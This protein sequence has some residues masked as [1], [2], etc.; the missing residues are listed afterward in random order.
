MK[1]K[2]TKAK[3][4]CR[5][6]RTGV[7]MNEHSLDAIASPG[8]YKI[9]ACDV[10]TSEG[11]P[12]DVAQG[13]ISAYLEVSVTNRRR[14]NLKSNTIGQT[15]TLTDGSGTTAMY[16]RNSVN[17]NGKDVWE[18]W[19]EVPVN[20]ELGSVTSLDGY[21]TNG[22][23]RGTYV[24]GGVTEEFVLVVVQN[25]SSATK[26]V[27]QYKYAL[28]SDGT[29]INKVRVGRIGNSVTWGTWTEIAAI[30]SN[31]IQD[32]SVTAAKLSDDVREKV[33]L[34]PHLY[35]KV[36]ADEH[37]LVNGDIIV[38]QAREVYSR[39]GKR[40]K[41]TFL[42]RTTA[43]GTTISD[44]VASIKQIGGNI[45]KNLVDGTSIIGWA[46]RPDTDVSINNGIITIKSM[47]TDGKG[48]LGY[49]S[50]TSSSTLISGHKF[51]ASCFIKSETMPNNG[52]IVGQSNEDNTIRPD[53]SVC[54]GNNTLWQYIS[55]YEALPMLTYYSMFAIG[56]KRTEGIGEIYIKNPLLVDLTEMYGAGNEPTKEECDKM[57]GV[58]APLPQGLTVAQPT[59]LKSVG[60]NQWNPI[61][62]MEGKGFVDG[63]LADVADSTIAIVECLPCQVGAGEN[64]GYVI[65][66]GEGEEWS[67][68]GVEV[69][70][71]PINPLDAESELYL[72]KL[73]KDATY[74]T[75]LPGIAGYLLVVTPT[76]DKLCAHLHWSG[77]RAATDYEP[78]NEST[79]QLPDIP[80]MSEWG[81]AG[82]VANGNIVQDTIDLENNKYIKRIG[83]I[84]LNGAE[85]W[86]FRDN[87]N[88][89]YGRIIPE[90]GAITNNVVIEAAIPFV[91]QN[92]TE[93][94]GTMAVTGNTVYINYSE[95]VNALGVVEFK[96]YLRNNPIT[97]YYA[98]ATP[99]EY[100]IVTKSAPNYIGGDYGVEQFTGS[101][102]PLAAN[103]LL[104][105]R[106]LVSETRNF[107]DQLYQNIGVCDSNNVANY[108]TEH[109]D[110]LKSNTDT[111]VK[112]ENCFSQSLKDLKV[113]HEVYINAEPFELSDAYLSVRKSNDTQQISLYSDNNVVAN[114]WT[115]RNLIERG[116]VKLTPIKDSGVTAYVF[117]DFTQVDSSGVS[118]VSISD[119]RVFTLAYSPSIAAEINSGSL[120]DLYSISNSI[121]ELN[122][123]VSHHCSY[124][125]DL[126]YLNLL[127]ELY[128]DGINSV[129]DYPR[130]TLR[131]LSS[132]S[133][134]Q[135]TLYS[136]YDTSAIANYWTD[137]NFINK[138]IVKLSQSNNSGVTAYAFV[139]F[140]QL[141]ATTSICIT[142]DNVKEIAFSPSIA[143]YLNDNRILEVEEN[144]KSLGS[145]WEGK[146]LLAIG[147]SITTEWSW[148]KR[149][150]SKCAAILGMNVR[151]HAKGGIGL[152]Q[153][154][155]GDGSGD[156]PEGYDPD[157][158]G[159]EELYALNS[160]DVTDVD[161]IVLHGMYN[162]R[163]IAKTAF[164]EITDMYPAQ[165]TYL[166]RLQYAIS[167]IY[168]ELEKAGNKNCK[169]VICSAHKYGKYPY[170][171]LSAYDD[172]EP[173]RLGAEMV[174]KYHSLYFIDLMNL[175]NINKYNWD[176]FSLSSSPYN[177]NY[178]PADG[179]LDG[180][181]KPFASLDVAPSVS[182]NS[183]KY[184]T[185]SDK[186][187]CYKSDGTSWIWE[188][189]SAIWNGD[190]LHLNQDGYQRIAEYIAGALSLV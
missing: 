126:N 145:K 35:D 84:V 41:A 112:F 38:G 162:E 146:R 19:A 21:T 56:D 23:F 152:I 81:L 12:A 90:D 89:Y 58:M 71:S 123:V 167:R 70:L 109:I 160:E 42:R 159:V 178:I 33:E 101:K 63:V 24:D 51:Y 183:G 10:S 79:V 107:L 50:Y 47:R 75:Y 62:V 153:M 11:F 2:K 154:V 169:V 151:V 85:N 26:R 132:E 103:I 133:A 179:V 116:V 34:V 80:Q 77:D 119:T 186:D 25:S 27:S 20:N 136:N 66:Y 72:C 74:D 173:I 57:F 163:S 148:E 52:I 137:R 91:I 61:N 175:G 149:W 135:I 14:D 180:T 13:R 88:G 114:Y 37:A 18:Q 111:I 68:S 115:D 187:G 15:I 172:G 87:N 104:Y 67:D 49:K 53:F 31:D 45:V 93:S 128:I 131:I 64:N 106:S 8:Y 100:P 120:I 161:V 118:Y 22:V 96:N 99:E 125:S 29:V 16:H 130:L 3:L 176:K 76:T 134:Q 168:D 60:Y 110:Y 5:D 102:I 17:R 59:A 9:E 182:A 184:I 28:L 46:V 122:D 30:T 155:D 65:G 185:I 139:D 98:L 83:K 171:N 189:T 82:I 7:V 43:G 165:N 40:D 121:I 117:A 138:G 95:E 86:I 156:A 1:Q 124:S 73:E 78:Y 39:Q 36:V 108:I 105:M 97:I 150:P 44:G 147:A 157:D 141:S 127:P 164:G 69:Y 142:K 129:S 166:G 94:Y 158:F 188:Y 54:I 48:G 4:E 181:N 174:A 170:S 190:Q 144:L 113:V 177:A 143:A 140:T 6:I 92:N 32:A 55:L